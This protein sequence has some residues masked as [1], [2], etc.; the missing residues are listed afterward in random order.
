MRLLNRLRSWL[1]F[2]HRNS[3]VCGRYFPQHH[4]IV[5]EI[6]RA[7]PD[8]D[9]QFTRPW[10]GMIFL[11][12]FEIFQASRRSQPNQPHEDLLWASKSR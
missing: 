8:P 12:Q 9:Q 7:G 11:D 6:Q 3:A 4:Q 1:R 10:F 5:M 2:G